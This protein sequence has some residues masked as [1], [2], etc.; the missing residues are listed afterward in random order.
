MEKLVERSAQSLCLACGLCCDGTIFSQVPLG[1][2]EEVI[3]LEESGIRIISDKASRIFKQPCPAHKSCVCKIYADRPLNCRAYQCSVLKRFKKNE[4][5]RDEALRIIR[6]TTSSRE[7]LKRQM[8]GGGHEGSLE[9]L[10]KRFWSGDSTLIAKEKDLFRCFIVLQKL[11]DKYFRAK[12]L[13]Q[14]SILSST[15][16]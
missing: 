10:S 11:L 1:P 16:K 2:E 3:L 6:I 14:W 9:G 15:K 5:N 4:I 8:L 13:F 12:P 7:D